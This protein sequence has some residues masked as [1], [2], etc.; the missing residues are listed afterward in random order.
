MTGYMHPNYAQSFLE[1]GIPRELPKCG[2]WVLERVIPGFSDHD[3]MG[4]YPLFVCHDWSKLH[5][6]LAEIGNELV[7]LSLVTDPFGEYDLGCLNKCFDL[8]M[9]FKEHFVADLNQPISTLVSKSHQSTVRRAM[10]N[11]EVEICPDPMLYLGEWT[12]LFEIL[13][14]RHN[15]TGIRAFSQTS[16]AKQLNIPGMV[17]FKA[18]SKSVTVGLDL[19]YVHGEVAYG[20]LV[21]INPLGYKLRASYALK[22]HLFQYFADKV[23]WLD[24]GGG[25]GVEIGK[26]DGLSDFKQGWSSGVR[27]AYLCGRIFDHERYGEI[28]K[29]KG[30]AATA[31]FPAYR[32]GEFE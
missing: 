11:V 31:Y 13:V 15:I 5:V 28:V 3:A 14:E 22:W 10:Q 25:A 4:C 16:F 21:A 9:P 2:G 19:W 24:L 27:T 26:R 7:S 18:V 32:K 29:A 17:M 23:R 12:E 8:V 1:W 6:D 20:H 30:I